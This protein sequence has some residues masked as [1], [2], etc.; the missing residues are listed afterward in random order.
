MQYTTHRNF[1]VV[2]E[3]DKIRGL[4]T[5]INEA[6]AQLRVRYSA[7]VGQGVRNLT[8]GDRV[9]FEIEQ[10]LNGA[11]AVRVAREQ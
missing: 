4:G 2:R 7:I 9:S 3:F 1:G 8:S 6:G 11:N 5:I 10:T